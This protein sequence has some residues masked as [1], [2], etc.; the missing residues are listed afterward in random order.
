MKIW[1]ETK[2]N[3]F[4]AESGRTFDEIAEI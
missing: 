4:S 3:A 2:W 1:S